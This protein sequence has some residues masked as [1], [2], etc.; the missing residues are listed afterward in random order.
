VLKVSFLRQIPARFHFPDEVFSATFDTAK[1]M[2]K[3]FSVHPKI[4]PQRT[5][6][7][8]FRCS[9][10]LLPTQPITST[11]ILNDAIV[12][13]FWHSTFK[14]TSEEV[15]AFVILFFKNITT[16]PFIDWHL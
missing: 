2:F 16:L 13:A 8:V 14:F 1:A 7:R 4:Y 11:S 3:V 6:F 12:Q 5:A 10:L 15:F 9:K